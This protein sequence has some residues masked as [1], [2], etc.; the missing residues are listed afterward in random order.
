MLVITKN[1]VTEESLEISEYF[2]DDEFY[3]QLLTKQEVRE[4]F[5]N[6]LEVEEATVSRIGKEVEEDKYVLKK[7]KVKLP[8]V[9]SDKE[10]GYY[11]RL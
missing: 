10:V 5:L 11:G 4:S 2:V 3:I 9:E 8:E 1:T 6:A 7:I